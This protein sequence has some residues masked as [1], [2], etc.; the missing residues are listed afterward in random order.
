MDLLLVPT[1]IESRT[2]F[3]APVRLEFGK[4]QPA[5][6]HGVACRAALCGFGLAAAGTGALS[7]IAA[8]A[9]LQHVLLLGTAGSYDAE[10]NPVG[11]AVTAASVHCFGIGVPATPHAASAGDQAATP[12]EPTTVQIPG[13][14]LWP[15]QFDLVVPPDWAASPFLSVATAATSPQQATARR[16]AFPDI[17]AEEMEG[18]AVALACHMSNRRLTMVRG[19]SNVAG[20]R[21]KSN[22]RIDSA[23]AAVR[24]QLDSFLAR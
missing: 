16:Q 9:D 3:D 23:M 17:V 18:Y 6:I 12:C 1:A 24:D 14:T 22:W 10:K 4:P 21:D 5:T 13:V 19:I 20:D 15:N 7:A 2:L 8:A 11:T